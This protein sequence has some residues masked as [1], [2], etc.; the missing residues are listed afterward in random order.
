M[1][2]DEEYLGYADWSEREGIVKVAGAVG[3]GSYSRLRSAASYVG[4][5]LSTQLGHEDF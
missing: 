3:G 4:T 2:L 5:A 1:S